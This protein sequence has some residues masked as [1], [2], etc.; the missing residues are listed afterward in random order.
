MRI[1]LF[2]QKRYSFNMMT[3]EKTKEYK[4]KLERERLVL[5]DEIKRNEMPTDF[6]GDID[7]ESDETENFGNQLAMVQGLKDRLNEIDI[8]LGKIQSEKYGIC[9]KCSGEI[10]E[11]VLDIDPESRFCKK[12]KSSKQN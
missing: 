6:G 1:D 9:E 5:I 3:K 11:E 8:A 2:F 7:D 10:E 4:N 12:C